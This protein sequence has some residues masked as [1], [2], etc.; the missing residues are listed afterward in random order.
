MKTQKDGCLQ[1]KERLSEK[2]NP[3]DIF[4]WDFQTPKLC[5]NSFLYLSHLVSGTLFSQPEQTSEYFPCTPPES[6]SKYLLFKPPTVSFKLCESHPLSKTLLLV[7]SPSYLELLSSREPWTTYRL[8]YIITIISLQS[9][10]YFNC[11][12]NTE[13]TRVASVLPYDLTLPQHQILGTDISF[14]RHQ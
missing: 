11:F 9:S 7:H 13:I 4:I 5:G 8:H 12:F 10:I 14:Q 1:S 2:N 6:P 3:A